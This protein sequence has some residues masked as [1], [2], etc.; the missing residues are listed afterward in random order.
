MIADR[1]AEGLLLLVCVAAVFAIC[2]L[3]QPPARHP[4]GDEVSYLAM[5]EHFAGREDTVVYYPYHNRILV[6]FLASLIPGGDATRSFMV[7]N[8]LFA[9]LGVMTLH[10]AWKKLGIPTYLA[11]L[12]SLWLLLHWIGIVRFYVLLP[13]LVD[14]PAYLFQAL[15]LHVLIRRNYSALV[16]LA[17]IATLQRESFL[18]V[19]AVLFGYEVIARFSRGAVIPLPMQSITYAKWKPSPDG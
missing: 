9:G 10:A 6:P 14:V 4:I 7:L 2:L 11:W 8:F 3:T 19:M 12:S 16:W 17:P 13:L 15:F 5:Y 1:P 18:V